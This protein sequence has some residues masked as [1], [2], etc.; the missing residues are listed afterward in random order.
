M[1]SII[2]MP[3]QYNKNDAIVMLLS[4]FANRRHCF[5]YATTVNAYVNKNFF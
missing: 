3:Y 1:V 2:M 5:K 4:M